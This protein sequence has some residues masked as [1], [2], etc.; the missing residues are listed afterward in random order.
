MVFS[1]DGRSLLCEYCSRNQTLSAKA[2]TDEQDFIL[3]MATGKGHRKPVATKT[4]NCRGCGAQFVLPP[5]VISE[6][7]AYCGSAHV[8]RMVRNLVEPD[9]IVPMAFGQR[10]AAL[11]LV[12]WMK[13]QNIEPGG[14]VQAPRGMYLP[15]WTFDIMG[16]IPWNGIVYRDKREVPVSGERAVS[17]DDIIVYGTPKLADMLYKIIKGFTLMG[18]P[19]Y[20][21]RYLAGWPAEVSQ[22]MMSQASLDARKQAVIRVRASIRS[23][24]GYIKDLSYSTSNIAITSFK[25]VLIPIWVT[26]YPLEGR[27]FRVII[28][29]Q[30]GAVYGETPSR[31]VMGWLEDVLGG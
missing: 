3:A 10:D 29:G 8:V 15:L 11:R 24:M 12:K 19:A 30:T 13:G 31:G 5:Q 17:F 20:D 14:K 18:A 27:T 4:F 23:E 7:C 28:N 26:E 9:S 25:L 2:P 6:L 16:N 22:T 1:P 21:P